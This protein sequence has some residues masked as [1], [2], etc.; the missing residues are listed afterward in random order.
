MNFKA[1]DALR[2]VWPHI[3]QYWA[4][5]SY[6]TDNFLY[7]LNTC[8]EMVY[9]ENWF[10]WSW[11]HIKEAFTNYTPDADWV[12]TLITTYPIVEI[13]KFRTG[14]MTP[15][16]W[17]A[18]ACDCPQP[19]PNPCPETVPQHHCCGCHSCYCE[20]TNWEEHTYTKVLPQ[21]K[22]CSGE[23]QVSGWD[24]PWMWWLSW[25][26]IKVKPHCNTAWLRVTYYRGPNFIK[27]FDDIVPLPQSR[28]ATVLPFLMASFVNIDRSA[29]FA[30]LYAKKIADLKNQDNIFPKTMVFDPNYPFYGT[31]NFPYYLW[32]SSRSAL[33]P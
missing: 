21:N 18:S 20:C 12:I 19:V 30:W 28:V 1:R 8:V 13:D 22:L 10:L 2:F 27:T 16:N 15:I 31:W 23:Y 33:N 17:V 26:I 3:W 25:R 5:Y 4:I 11:E 29:F 14:K 7:L 32:G 24:N 6:W 9:W